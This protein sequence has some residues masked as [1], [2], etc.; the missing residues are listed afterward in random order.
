MASSSSQKNLWLAETRS[1]TAL[2][3]MTDLRVKASAKKSVSSVTDGPIFMKKSLFSRLRN[4][5]QPYIT[6]ALE[7]FD[8]FK[9]EKVPLAPSDEVYDVVLESVM[10]TLIEH[11]MAYNKLPGN[12]NDLTNFYRKLP[13][14]DLEE[15]KG[16]LTEFSV[17]SNADK[18][19]AMCNDKAVE[20]PCLDLDASFAL[21]VELLNS[22]SLE[23]DI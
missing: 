2:V 15:I 22:F 6:S 18:V 13:R 11:H 8:Y 21:M 4:E 5:L 16:L 19:C 12:C 23:P 10:T 9:R 14:G 3:P 17:A 1:H 20:T 7:L